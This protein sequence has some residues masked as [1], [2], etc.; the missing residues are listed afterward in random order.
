MKKM[1]NKMLIQEKTSHVRCEQSKDSSLCKKMMKKKRSFSFVVKMF[2]W[3]FFK[4]RETK[5]SWRRRSSQREWSKNKTRKEGTRGV[6]CLPLFC[7]FVFIFRYFMSMKRC[8]ML[9]QVNHLFLLVPLDEDVEHE[10]INVLC[11][12][13]FSWLVFLSALI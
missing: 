2:S 9:L 10:G 7:C 6:N 5:F 1:M 3:L 13:F 12:V 11:H 4:N 8:L